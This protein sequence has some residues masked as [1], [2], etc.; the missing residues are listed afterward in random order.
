M[1]RP[2]RRF[3]AA[4][5]ALAGLGPYGP[6]HSETFDVTVSI[7]SSSKV[8]VVAKVRDDK[9]SC[10]SLI[11]SHTWFLLAPSF[12]SL[13]AINTDTGILTELTNASIAEWRQELTAEADKSRDVIDKIKSDSST[14]K[15]TRNILLTGKLGEAG[16]SI[17]PIRL[18]PLQ[19]TGAVDAPTLKLLNRRLDEFRLALTKEIPSASLAIQQFT[20]AFSIEH[21]PA[22]FRSARSSDTATL[23]QSLANGSTA[24][25]SLK[26]VTVR[27]GGTL[28]AL[29]RSPTKMPL[30]DNTGAAP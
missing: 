28:S 11:N 18:V 2:L 22:R 29:F 8:S 13:T 12:G 7:Q 17:P 26:S 1:K 4:G 24:Y 30:S 16:I 25:P 9:V 5:V 23:R 3:V 20:C 14:P 15:D 27:N 19:V 6:V 21:L 10:V